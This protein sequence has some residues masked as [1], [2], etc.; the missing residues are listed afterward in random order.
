MKIQ[1]TNIPFGPYVM[2]TT[3]PEDMRLRLLKD[4]KKDLRSYHKRLAG[5]LHTQL[6]Y[7]QN[8]TEWF[9]KESAP[10]W[11]AYREGWSN[12][13]GQKNEGCELNA[14]DLWVNFMKPG[15]FN[16]VHTHGGDYSF[17]IFLDIP[18][19]LT[20]E[21]EAFEGTSAKPGSLMF[22]F[23]QQ[24]KPKWAF[25]GHAHN[26]TTGQ[27][28]IFPALLQHW[29]VPFKSNCTRVSV[30]GNLEILN[31]ENLSNEFF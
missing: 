3:I 16:P 17:V 13:S 5:H 8:T 10:I 27:M 15:D 28:I 25:T 26:P 20:E 2:V 23:T 18:K 21:Q 7:N 24:A 29:V 9:Y 1:Y 19:K 31:R 22:E 12:W 14:H 6:K 11:Q 4:G 30:S